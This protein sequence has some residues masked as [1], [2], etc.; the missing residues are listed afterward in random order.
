MSMH[1]ERSRE[2]VF[3]VTATSQEISALVAGARMAL[4]AMR[5]APDPPPPAAIEILERVLR[6]FDAAR[7]RLA[8]TPP[9]GG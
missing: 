2:N 7:D 4:D 3:T 8:A 5:S 6:D 9:D 1:I